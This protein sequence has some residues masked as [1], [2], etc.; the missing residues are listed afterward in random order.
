MNKE[1]SIIWDLD[2]T[3]LDS[4]KVIIS[5][6]CNVCKEY[7]FSYDKN[8]LRKEVIAT[9]VNDAIK[10]II[11]GSDVPFD[12]FKNRCSSVNS[13]NNYKIKAMKHA[14]KTLKILETKG[15]NN[16]VFTHRGKSTE[17]VL[18]NVK[19]YDYFIEIVSS[20]NGFN[21]KPD[22]GALDYLINKYKMDKDN[23][24]YVG[25]RVID[26]ECASNAGIKSIL[27]LGNNNNTLP[28]GKETYVVHDLLEITKLL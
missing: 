27:Y 18:K 19:L 7:G 16:Y 21:R 14:S 3:L 12:T 25:D 17:F 28:T 4:Y 6:L 15:I 20:L 5:G 13:K 26:I 9:S 11:D 23:T 1:I 10:R 2:G 22:P 24:Y 8:E